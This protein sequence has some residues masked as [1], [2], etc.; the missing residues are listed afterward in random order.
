M[1]GLEVPIPFTKMHGTRNDYIFI[2][3]FLT[4]VAS[5]AELAVKISDRHSG[6]GSDGLILVL[7]PLGGTAHCRMEMYNADGSRGAMCGNGIRCLGKFFVDRGVVEGSRDLAELMVET[8][9]GVKRLLLSKGVDGRVDEVAVDMGPPG[10]ARSSVPFHCTDGGD[11]D[12]AIGI[13]VECDGV[14]FK[15]SAVSMGNPH[16]IINLDEITSASEGA[17]VEASLESA[18]IALWGARI[19][20]LPSFP[21]G[22]NVSFVVTPLVSSLGCPSP[23]CA[24]PCTAFLS[25]PRTDSV[26]S[27]HE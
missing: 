17:G 27:E 19:G 23:T 1:A 14:L 24:H 7:P 11:D 3:G 18:P 21:R 2:D 9:S 25:L 12:P 15:L 6:V 13:P 26:H 22:A 5:P 10:L 8:D 16:A 4:P 20:R